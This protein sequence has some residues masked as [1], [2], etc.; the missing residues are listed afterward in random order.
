MDLIKKKNTKVV[1]CQTL[2]TNGKNLLKDDFGWLTPQHHIMSWALSFL[3]LNNFYSI[4][5]LHS[6]STGIALIKD[7]LGLPYTN[8]F[9]DYSNITCQSNLW[10]LPKLL[11]YEKQEKPFLHVD[12]DV[13]I[14]QPVKKELL[15]SKLI[16]QNLE[17]GTLYYKRLLTPFAEQLKYI[18]GFLKRNLLSH[19]MLSYNMG[20]VGGYDVEFFKRYVAIAKDFIDKNDETILNS[21]FNILFEQ[22]LFYSITLNEKKTVTC[23]FNKVLD[24]NGYIKNE[25]ASFPKADQLGY[26][27]LIGNYKRD[28]EV[29]DWLVRYLRREDEEV[30][31]R[32]I[33]LFKNQH[34]FYNGKIK[35]LYPTI[36]STSANKF[37]FSKSEHFATVLNPELNFNSNASLCRYIEKSENGLLKELLKYE[38]KIYRIC[39]KFRKID[40]FHLK[41]LENNLMKLVGFLTMNQG[42]RM[43]VILSRN[44]YIEII[45]STFDWT[46]MQIS[47][48]KNINIQCSDKKDIVIGIIPELFFSGYREVILDKICINLIV[49]TETKISYKDL[50]EKMNALLPP[51]KNE[52]EYK[53]FYELI[54]LKIEFLIKN[55]ILIIYDN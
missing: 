50:L 49:L 23:L 26:M 22:L 32:I 42:D 17:K 9:D 2:W 5:N 34:S 7:K 29:C 38:Q 1:I 46:T 30:F 20:I 43:P 15:S 54:F 36:T 47:N 37:R 4:V 31:L 51:L 18:P 25:I 10:A 19:D 16:A 14:W 48:M 12:G 24:D 6:D 40:S 53:D 41:E 44:P 39:T 45:H 3:K 35:E 28:K 13:F 11:T 27:H 8:F 52:K 55:K 33:S 21:N